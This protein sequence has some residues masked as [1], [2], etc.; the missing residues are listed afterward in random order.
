VAIVLFSLWMP[1]DVADWGL[2]SKMATDYTSARSRPPI[3]MGLPM[4]RS[5]RVNVGRSERKN[6]WCG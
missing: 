1:H 3:R 6:I 2:I 4:R 5:A